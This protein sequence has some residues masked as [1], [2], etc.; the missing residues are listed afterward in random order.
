MRVVSERENRRHDDGGRVLL[1]LAGGC[2]RACRRLKGKQGFQIPQGRER[3]TRRKGIILSLIRA[4]GSRV[5]TNHLPS[6]RLYDS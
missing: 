3:K 6:L 5:L 2:V 4:S 1:C